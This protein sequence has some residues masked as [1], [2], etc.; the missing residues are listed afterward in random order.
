MFRLFGLMLSILML[1]SHIKF[2]PFSHN[3]LLLIFNSLQQIYIMDPEIAAFLKR[4]LT[5]IGI[6][7]FWMG[8]NSTFGIM[9]GYAYIE[10]KLQIG[11]IVFYV[12]V[13]VGTPATIW[14]LRKLW[15]E[16][17]DFDVYN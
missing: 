4:I 10:G 8:V 15:K 17:S 11:N 2:L 13:V 14:Y 7:L 3:F 6:V 1:F 12:W 5:T 16:Q 9:L